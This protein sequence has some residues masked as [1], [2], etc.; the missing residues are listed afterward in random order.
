M[1]RRWDEQKWFKSMGI[2]ITA[3]REQRGMSPAE[4]AERAGLPAER[5]AVIEAGAVDAAWSELRR[6]AYAIE[7][8]LPQL[9]QD[10]EMQEP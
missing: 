2:T 1:S 5:L 7:T 3:L 4:L 8:D 9:I 6:I 10:C